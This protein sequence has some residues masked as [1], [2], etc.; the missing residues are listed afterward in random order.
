MPEH[1]AQS[2]QPL[3]ARSTRKELLTLACAIDRAAWVK[4][5]RTV[6]QK[7]GAGIARSVIASRAGLYHDDTLNKYLLNKMTFILTPA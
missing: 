6:A 2:L 7:K 5:C 4:A 3:T 1:T